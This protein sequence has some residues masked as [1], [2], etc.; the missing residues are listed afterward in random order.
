[1]TEFYSN[2]EFET[3]IEGLLPE[4]P[5]RV[6]FAVGRFQPPTR[7]HYKVI[8][9]M[10]EFI[11][12]NPKLNLEAKPIVVVISGEK[13]S[14]DK[15]KNP[16]TSDERISFM[17]ASGNANGVVFLTAKNAFLALGAIRDAGF[18]P[19]AIGAG[20]DRA[21]EYLRML[22][23]GFKKPN[24]NPIEHIAIPGLDRTGNAI[25]TKKDDKQSALDK[26]LKTLHSS[27]DLEDEEVSGSVARRAVELGYREEFAVITGLEKKVSLANKLFDKLQKI[28]EKEKE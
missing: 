7:A 1:M 15:Q 21:K 25:V 5:K 18:E 24:G 4:Q 10:K 2:N 23:K 9:K 17:Q 19:I 12:N 28:F 27:G 11:R 6:A 8:D 13:S 14:E 22:D 20:S 26:A 16:L 3:L